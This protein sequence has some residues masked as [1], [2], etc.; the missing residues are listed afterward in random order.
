MDR[1]LAT[2]DVVRDIQP[3]PNAD[4][5]EVV[6]VRGW[7]CVVKKDEFFIGDKI[8]YFEVDSLLDHTNPIFEFLRPRGFR[9]KTI[10]LRGQ[11]SQGL[12]MSTSILPAGNYE[13]GDDVTDILK[14]EKYE[15]P[16]PANLRGLVK[17]SFPTNILNKTDEERVQNI[18][19][20]LT[21]YEH[22][23]I[24]FSEKLDGTSCTCMLYNNEFRVCSR[25]LE[26]LESDE[27]LY[28]K[29]ARSEDVENKLRIVNKNI[30]VQGEIIGF[31]VQNNRYALKSTEL[32][33]FNVIDLDTRYYYTNMEIVEFCEKYGFKHV[34]MLGEFELTS[35]I[36]DLVKISKDRSKLNPKIHREGIV[37]R[38]QKPI[39][40]PNFGR[41]SFKVINPNYLLKY[42]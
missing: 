12:V 8:V 16:I 35:N 32:W 5:I 30:A 41:L 1:K 22:E 11:I 37:I 34:P 29:V 39:I 17:G 36:D 9:I 27:N 38:S 33:V 28:W 20:I 26:L 4:N 23:P 6:T 14:V 42:E 19:D 18:Q 10:K 21:K 25:N 2:V 7:H 3:I 24:S 15:V 13:I 31:G 40:D